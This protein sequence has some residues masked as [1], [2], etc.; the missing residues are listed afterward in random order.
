MVRPTIKAYETSISELFS[1]RF[2]FF[3]PSFQRPY[4]WTTEHAGELLEDLQHAMSQGGDPAPYFLGTIVVIK[5]AEQPETEVVDGQQRL[6]TLTLLL[7]VLRDLAEFGDAHQIDGY[8]RQKGNKFEDIQD[9]F[10][11]ALREQDNRIFQKH[12]QII[13]ATDKLPDPGQFVSDSQSRFIA[14]AH[15]YRSKLADWPA[16]SRTELLKYIVRK[17]FLVVVQVPDREMSYRVFSVMN[18]RG[19]DL[20]PTDVLKAEIIGAMQPE[21]RESYNEIWELLEEG[22]GRERFRELFGLIDHIFHRQKRRTSLE[23]SFRDHVLSH[24]PP[25][26][27]VDKYLEPLGEAYLNIVDQT[28]RAPQH[29][30]DVNKCLK[31]LNLLSFSDWQPAALG[32]MMQFHQQPAKLLFVLRKIERLAYAFFILGIHVD[33]RIRRFGAVLEELIRSPGHPTPQSPINLTS[34]EIDAIGDV[35][36]GPIYLVKRVRKLLLLRLDEAISSGTATYDYPIVSIEHVLPQTP[37]PDS[38]W[39]IDF[40][41]EQLRSDWLHRLANLVLLSK[42]KNASAGN[43]DFPNKKERY[44]ARGGTSPFAIT[45]Q[46]LAEPHWTPA[47]LEQRQELLVATL[48][49]LWELHPQEHFGEG[50]MQIA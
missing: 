23:Q 47:V 2:L 49:D 40:P 27:F 11:I 44:F 46:V 1:A 4:A 35:L 19:M 18:D 15:Y 21:D 33:K 12:V 36:N 43:L 24:V 13:G 31:H 22:L 50:Q 48:A 25:K 3:M 42:R 41:D 9:K 10:R 45:S 7:A 32:A 16:R 8:I 37:P 29:A 14:N 28:Y 26:Q 30:S 20:S 6:A 17:C 5:T 34:E 39:L 38:Q